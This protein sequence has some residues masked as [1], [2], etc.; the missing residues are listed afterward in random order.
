LA[1]VRRLHPAHG[2]NELRRFD[3]AKARRLRGVALALW[4]VVTSPRA[5]YCPVFDASGDLERVE[6]PLTLEHCQALGAHNSPDAGRRRMLNEAGA[7]VCAADKS[8]QAFEA[9]GGRG[10]DSFLRIVRQRPRALPL[11][12][13]FESAEQLSLAA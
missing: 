1:H 4:I 13:P 9:H 2:R 5:P 10:R 3:W 11:D 6:V 7:R 12:R 8:F